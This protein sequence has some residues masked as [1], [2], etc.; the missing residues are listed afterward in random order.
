MFFALTITMKSL[1]MN[2][3]LIVLTS[4][5]F[6]TGIWFSIQPSKTNQTV[7]LHDANGVIEKGDIAPEIELENTK[8]KKMKLS[9]LRGK[10]VLIDFWAS[11]CGPCRA[12]NPNVVS[13]YKKYATAK[14]K[15]ASG[16][17]IYSVSLDTKKDAWKSAIKKD[18]L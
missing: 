2:A 16:F 3:P 8:G 17:E 15:N 6:A 14:F 13:A 18:A 11:W 1:K 4:L 12:E 5:F 9:A 10:V 7:V